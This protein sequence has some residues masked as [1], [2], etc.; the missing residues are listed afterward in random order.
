MKEW[1]KQNFDLLVE[2]IKNEFNVLYKRLTKKGKTV[3]AV[4]IITDYDGLTAYFMASTLESLKKKHK[5]S[6]WV[7]YCWMIRNDD[8]DVK[9]G[10]NEFVDKHLDYY[11]EYIVPRFADGNYDYSHD[12]NDNIEMFTLAMKAAKAKLHEQWGEIM[13]E[14][15]F[16]VSISG[17]DDMTLTSAK[18]INGA[19]KNLSKLIKF[20]DAF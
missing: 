13:T 1:Q 16:L 19:S 4:T 12:F 11:D 17:E 5:D 3:Y 14:I 15:I 6:K 9:L 10:L 20:F 2:C 7:P 8:G 18:K